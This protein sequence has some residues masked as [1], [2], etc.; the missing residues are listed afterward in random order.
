MWVWLMIKELYCKI[1]NYFVINYTR[2]RKSVKE[3]KEFLSSLIEPEDDFEYSFNKY[4]CQMYYHYPLVLRALYQVGA[5]FLLPY[6]YLTYTRNRRKITI[7]KNSKKCAL[8]RKNKNMR[9]D[10]VLPEDFLREKGQLLEVPFPSIKAGVL[11]E[12]GKKIVRKTIKSYWKHPYFLL[13]VTIKIGEFGYLIN[14]YEPQCILSYVFERDLANPLESYYCEESG[15]DHICFMH[16]DS[17]YSVDRAFS[18]PTYYCVWDKH[19]EK[20]FMELRCSAKEFVIYTPRKWMMD[21]VLRANGD[22]PYFAT[23]YFSAETPQIIQGVK[24]VFDKLSSKGLSCKVR[25]H[26]RFSNKEYIKQVF[27][28]YLVEDSSVLLQKSFYDTHYVIALNS[29]VLSQA[30]FSGKDIIIDDITDEQKYRSLYERNYMM[31]RYPLKKLS[32]LLNEVYGE[33]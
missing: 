30:Y 24:S 1:N 20:M 8:I 27:E 12:K 18:R 26:P 7:D 25:L 32:V 31:V 10:D 16:G 11:D 29:T 4:L 28:E 17:M 3:Q 23:Y 19:Y 14:K 15:I 9:T 33:Q 22:Y 21:N 13:I 2:K 5:L 6:I